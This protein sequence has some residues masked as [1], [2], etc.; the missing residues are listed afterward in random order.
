MHRK[1]GRYG[2]ETTLEEGGESAGSDYMEHT[3]VD[4]DS[5]PIRRTDKGRIYSRLPT[6]D[7]GS[8][9]KCMACKHPRAKYYTLMHMRVAYTVSTPCTTVLQ[10]PLSK[11]PATYQYRYK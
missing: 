6:T 7:R 8:R 2:V 3:M 4:T 11:G 9:P 5:P 1:M 10:L